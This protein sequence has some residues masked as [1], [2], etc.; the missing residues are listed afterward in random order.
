MFGEAPQV[1][2]I[3]RQKA[4]AIIGNHI[5]RKVAQDTRDYGKFYVENSNG[6]VTA[7]DNE[8]GECWT[9]DFRSVSSAR[10][11]LLKYED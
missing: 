11:W 5:E 10:R 7:I 4:A 6:T 9:E 3:S 2:K 8:H 1:R